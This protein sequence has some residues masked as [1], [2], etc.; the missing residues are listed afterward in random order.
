M[1]TKWSSNVLAYFTSEN[2]GAGTDQ[3]TLNGL[4]VDY[5]KTTLNDPKKYLVLTSNTVNNND[6]T[7]AGYGKTLTVKVSNAKYS[8]TSWAYGAWADTQGSFQI[9]LMSPIFEGTI[10]PAEGASV[11]IVANNVDG[12]NITSEM[13][14]ATDYTGTN[15]IEIMP[16][17]K[18]TDKDHPLA[19]SNTQIK[20]MSVDKDK[21]NTYISALAINPYTPEDK[22][23]ATPEK[24]GSINVKANPVV[25]DV[26][27]HIYV[28]VTDAWGYTNKIKLPV[29]ITKQ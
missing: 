1:I 16:N 20:K 29:T 2:T 9:K 3:T 6:P 10:K 8:N 27:T 21:N 26:D 14:V 28:S 13:I 19:W 11:K 7:E 4:T 15:R 17:A 23:T 18:G 22:D 12:S 25:N 5:K 24:L